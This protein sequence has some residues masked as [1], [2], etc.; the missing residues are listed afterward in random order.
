MEK[1]KRSL[2]TAVLIFLALGQLLFLEN[3][4]LCTGISE[5]ATFTNGNFDQGINLP[6]GGFRTLNAGSTDLTGWTISYGS[7][8]WIHTYWQNPTGSSYSID[9]SGNSVGSI[10]QT[11][12]TTANQSYKIS[13]W[14]AG[15]PDAAGLKELQVSLYGATDPIFN[16]YSFL[17]TTTGTTRTNMG[18]TLYEFLFTAG[19]P[20][21][22]INFTSLTGTAYGPAIA[23]VEVSSVPLPAAAWMLGAGLVGLVAIRRRHVIQREN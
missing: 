23:G 12:D 6:S 16:F 13:F 3:V 20:S 9:L 1:I 2:F 10:A 11:F 8:D 14:M 17:N 21:A 4:I 5:A 18:W 22:T 15:N 7:I 19:G